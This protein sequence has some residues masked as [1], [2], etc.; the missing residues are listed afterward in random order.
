MVFF[1]CD[2]CNETLK[3]NK[4]EQHMQRCRQ[5]FSVSCIDC[6]VSFAG[7]SYVKHTT[8]ISEAEKYQGALY[9]PKGKT[10]MKPQEIWMNAVAAVTSGTVPENIRDVVST[11]ANFDN[12]PRKKKK[13][14]N[15]LKNSQR[16]I[17]EDKIEQIWTLI[18]DKYEEM[19]PKKVE[20]PKKRKVVPVA[21]DSDSSEWEDSDSD[22]DDEE[23][24]KVQVATSDNTASPKRKTTSAPVKKIFDSKKLKTLHFMLALNRAKRR[25]CN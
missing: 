12:I 17:N 3:K 19:S 21:S 11:L 22:D 15:Y 9:K 6:S 25:I 2:G 18:S 10:K 4:V 20:V 5:C 1:T 14:V 7:R 24:D 23:E 8:C 16:Y 13:F